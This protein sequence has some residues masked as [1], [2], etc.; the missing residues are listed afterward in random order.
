[1][2]RN[3][4]FYKNLLGYAAIVYQPL[5][6]KNMRNR[7]K[8]FL[9]GRK[10]EVAI[11]KFMHRMKALNLVV[12]PEML[13]AIESPYIHNEWDVALKLERI[14]KHYELLSTIPSKLISVNSL[15]RQEIM[16]LD[17]V[18]SGASV[19]ID[20][21]PW[22]TREGELHVNLFR[23]DLRIAT[24]AFSL[25]LHNSE[26]VAYVGAVQGIHGGVSMEESLD[27]FKVLTKEFYG[28]RPRSLL[29][30]V[31]KVVTRKLGAK[32]MY[33]ISEEHRHHRHQYFNNDETTKFKNDYNLFWEEHNATR[34][35]SIGFYEISMMPAIKD[36]SEIPSK[37]R[38]Q[39]S[40]RYAVIKSLGGEINLG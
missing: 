10:D 25:G 9:A 28:L 38:S 24:M 37:K 1:M 16:S 20:Y 40:R 4:S 11:N 34:D 12:S 22:F 2:T 5:S 35:G 14:A 13:G 19:A 23:G 7:A 15:P 26:T 39:Y 21:A 17:E 32:K 36:L 3:V 30:E 18:S 31:L 8:F 6:L 29:L 33:G 27:I